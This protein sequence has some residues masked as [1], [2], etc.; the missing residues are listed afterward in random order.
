MIRYH[1][2]YPWHREGAYRHL[3]GPGDEEQLRAVRAFNRTLPSPSSSCAILTLQLTTCTPS[4]T[5]HQKSR[6]SSRTTCLLS[7]NT[8]PKSS[9]GRHC[10]NMRKR[11]VEETD[12]HVDII[13]ILEP[14]V[15]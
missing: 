6:S 15:L 14:A 9:I 12:H 8:S 1:S 13:V 3:M 11:K 10:L 5:S 4:L 2:F 7:T